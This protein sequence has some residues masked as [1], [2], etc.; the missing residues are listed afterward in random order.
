VRVENCTCLGLGGSFEP[1]SEDRQ[2]VV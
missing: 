1:D 2:V